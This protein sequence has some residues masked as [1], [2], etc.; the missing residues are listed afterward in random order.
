MERKA[1]IGVIQDMEEE[2]RA[3]PWPAALFWRGNLLHL[4]NKEATTQFE[5]V[6]KGDWN[7][8]RI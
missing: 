6:G 3:D 8:V 1:S 7:G 4:G 2:V 5:L